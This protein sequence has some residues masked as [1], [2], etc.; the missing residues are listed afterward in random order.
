MK[1]S[2]SIFI[3]IIFSIYFLWGEQI[4]F[5]A[6]SMSGKAG[7]S[8]STTILSDN[9]YIKTESMEIF[10]DVVELSGEDFRYIKARGNVSGK[11]LESKMDFSCDSL[12][13]DRTEK[14]AILKGSV[15][16]KDLEN[17]VN[18]E[19]ELIEYDEAKEIAILQISLS[20]RQKE[21]LCSGA[22]GIYYK[23]DQILELSGNAEIKQ[24]D[25]MFRAQHIKL[26]L[27]TQ[28]ISL[29]GNVKG[30]VK[31]QKGKQKVDKDTGDA[32]LAEKESLLE[33]GE[34]QLPI[35]SEAPDLKTTEDLKKSESMESPQSTDISPSLDKKEME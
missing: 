18:A 8:N 12:E 1:K 11:N 7:N 27:E 16:F 30:S 20:L 28:E 32:T 26:N 22:Y 2:I 33:E 34:S 21:N 35:E 23:K 4:E 6:G 29:G 14:I 24:N 17:D 31:D 3:F 5:S 19:A 13:Y 15:V 25:D 10:A 9:A